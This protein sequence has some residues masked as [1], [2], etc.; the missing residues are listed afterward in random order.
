[1]RPG[2]TL[3]LGLVLAPLLLAMAIWLW[4]RGPT[5]L[6]WRVRSASADDCQ[7][8]WWGD[9]TAASA[10]SDTGDQMPE[11]H[12]WRL[13]KITSLRRP[14]GQPRTARPNTPEELDQLAQYAELVVMAL[15]AG[16]TL[17]QARRK[18]AD[19]GGLSTG[20]V[21]KEES[22]PLLIAAYGL[23]EEL[24]APVAE[25]AASV[26]SVSRRRAAAMRRKDA[27]LAGP[28]ASM[29]LMTSLPLAG[30]VVVFVVGG[31]VAGTYLGSRA[32]ILSVLFGI[33]LT[34]LGWF[35]ASRTLARAS[36]PRRWPVRS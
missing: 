9:S 2:S 28:R 8:R 18:A 31:D 15:S 25:A 10:E 11:R 26:A 36:R 13:S 4:P 29:W 27:A 33:L 34:G 24:G 6:S 19:S 30:P 23:C 16:C 3:T 17:E 5:W 1:M 12:R 32:A 7:H 22:A 14:R 20:G 35:S 21:V